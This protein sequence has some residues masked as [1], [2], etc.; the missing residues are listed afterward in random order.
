MLLTGSKALDVHLGRPLNK[1][2]DW[3]FIAS[4]RE[5][6]SKGLTYG[7]KDSLSIGNIE[8]LN[9]ESL[10][11][12]RF[13]GEECSYLPV[14]MLDCNICTLQELYIQKRSH[15]HRPIKFD[16]HM[17]ELRAIKGAMTTLTPEMEEMLEERKKLT[18]KKYNDKAPSLRKTN[19][20][21]F[22]DYVT[23]YYVHDQLHEVVAYYQCPI[24]TKLKR[25][26][27]LAACERDL[28]EALSYRDKLNCVREE[29]YVIALERFIIPKLIKGERHTPFKVAF[30]MAHEKVCTT[31][32][33]GWFRDFAIDNFFEAKSDIVDF[34]SL[35]MSSNIKRIE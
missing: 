13:V 22:D 16:R 8:Y 14:A 29:C 3:D 24:Y 7:G 21:F 9:V 19:E 32:T 31:L 1:K 26:D 35:F 5:L 23:K 10:N 12:H 30:H 33:S 2:T 4:E 17:F 28:W 18:R 6:N 15:V 11:N 20:E 25:D 34:L 27:S